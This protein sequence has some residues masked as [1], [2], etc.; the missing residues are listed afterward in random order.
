[1]REDMN[2]IPNG[3]DFGDSLFTCTLN[4]VRQY[5]LA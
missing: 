3:Y 4:K 1:M 5:I 2:Y